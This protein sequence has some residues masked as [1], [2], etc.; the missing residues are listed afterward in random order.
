MPVN[1]ARRN[2]SYAPL[3]ARY[4]TDD[5]IASAGEKAELLYV[6]GMAFCAG[7]LSDGIITPTQL[8]RF[9]GVGMRD[10]KRR[11]DILV[12]HGLWEITDDGDYRIV[13]WLKWNLSRAEIQGKLAA[14]A[15][16]KAH[17]R[18]PPA[19]PRSARN[20]RGIQ[21]ESARTPIAYTDT[22]T[23]TEPTTERSW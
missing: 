17:P 14:D 23:H 20:P 5:A 19:V 7:E 22:D 6:R 18:T 3:S 16:R 8:R 13:T 10:A 4:Y 2:G 1:R 21:A 15:A 9:V 11:A 12:A